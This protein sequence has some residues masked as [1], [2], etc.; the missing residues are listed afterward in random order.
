VTRVGERV[1]FWTDEGVAPPAIVEV[2]GVTGEVIVE[3]QWPAS[4]RGRP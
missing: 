3:E 2:V 4:M 1:L